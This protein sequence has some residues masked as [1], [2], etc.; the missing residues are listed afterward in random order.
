MVVSRSCPPAIGRGASSISIA[1]SSLSNF[2][3]SSMVAGL[4]HSK[5]FISLS[6]DRLDLCLSLRWFLC[7]PA[8][9]FRE[10]HQNL[11]GSYRQL[12]DSQTTG[13]EHGIYDR[14]Q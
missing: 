13:I 10:S 9:V 12:T 4:V 6:F 14:A 3:A 11:V 1:L 5:A 8:L 2:T 7:S